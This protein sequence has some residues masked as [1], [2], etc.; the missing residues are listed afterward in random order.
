MAFANSILIVSTI[1][2][3]NKLLFVIVAVI[4]IKALKQLVVGLSELKLL[5]LRGVDGTYHDALEENGLNYFRACCYLFTLLTSSFLNPAAFA[6]CVMTDV[7]TQVA[8]HGSKKS[9]CANQ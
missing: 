6:G 5:H 1:L 4:A 2:G 7:A 8:I 3:L 9:S